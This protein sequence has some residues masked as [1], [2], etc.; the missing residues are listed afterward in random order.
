MA[1]AIKNSG[2]EMEDEESLPPLRPLPDSAIK[3]DVVDRHI[4]QQEEKKEEQTAKKNIQKQINFRLTEEEYEKYTKLF[5]AQGVS[6]SK[7]I[8]MWLDFG[9]S[10]IKNGQYEMSQYGIKEKILGRL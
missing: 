5:G 4:Q 10:A 9:Y 3:L 7:A 6:F 8:R 1:K 2:L